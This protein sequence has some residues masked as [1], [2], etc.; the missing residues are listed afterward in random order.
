MAIYTADQAQT[1]P[2]VGSSSFS[3][4]G[5]DWL[6]GTPWANLPQGPERNATAAAV[7][8]YV[9]N[10][11]RLPDQ[12]E[13]SYALPAFMGGDPHF[14]N[15]AQ[16]NAFVAGLYQQNQNSPDQIY[17]KQ[18]AQYKANAPQNYDQVNSIFKSLVD[19][20]ASQDELDHFG[21]LLASG[22]VD[23]Y[24]IQQFLQATPEYQ[25]AQ[26][27]KFRSG[28]N[29]ELAGYD[30]QAFDR[31]K[32]DV[33]SRYAQMGRSTSPALDVALTDLQAQLNANR[34]QFLAQT[35]VSQYAGNKSAAISDYQKSLDDLRNR[36]NA[37]ATAKYNTAV[38]N[39]S[40]L[41]D[42]TDYGTQEAAYMRAL[43]QYGGGQKPGPL[44][45]L[46]TGLNVANTASK[47]YAAA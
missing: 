31:E 45:Y 39:N 11:G 4:D 2:S 40:R 6:N 29:D 9:Q 33:I 47:I 43:G 26:D 44:D 19:R 10:F 18:Q 3:Y 8:A 7:Q 25:N 27:A 42:I 22:Q 24:Q 28:L 16:G 13:L 38:G 35:G 20:G 34:G 17:A 32:E 14:T 37:N 30:R 23:P 21:T 1:Q 46:N 5:K 36:T 41:N 12:H 15:V